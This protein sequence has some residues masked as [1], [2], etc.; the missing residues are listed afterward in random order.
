MSYVYEICLYNAI[1][2]GAFVCP[3]CLEGNTV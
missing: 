3:C 2:K 1:P